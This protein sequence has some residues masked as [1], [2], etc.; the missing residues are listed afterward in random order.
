MKSIKTFEEI[1]AWKD[2]RE[3]ANNIYALTN[4]KSFNND[5]SIGGA[6]RREAGRVMAKL[7]EGSDVGSDEAFV[8]YVK[9]ARE[10]AVGLQS[11]LYLAQD[12][13]CITED[14]FQ[15]IYAQIDELKKQMH[16]FITYLNRPEAVKDG[17]GGSKTISR[18]D[19]FDKLEN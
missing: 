9:T 2:A 13:K 1:K 8:P 14:E 15:K 18:K 5:Q 7:A 11:F 19:L 4:G 6:L 12:H 17:I 3:L 10:I 16:M